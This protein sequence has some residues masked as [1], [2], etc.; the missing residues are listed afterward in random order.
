MARDL[1]R[2]ASSL[3]G[4]VAMGTAYLLQLRATELAE[5]PSITNTTSNCCESFVPIG[6]SLYLQFLVRSTKVL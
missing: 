5:R 3:H 1:A 6:V 2:T 4:S